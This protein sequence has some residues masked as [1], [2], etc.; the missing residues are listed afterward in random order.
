MRVDPSAIF[1]IL[2]LE[3]EFFTDYDESDLITLDYTFLGKNPQMLYTG[4]WAD[5][6]IKIKHHVGSE[7]EV[8]T[9]DFTIFVAIG[10][11][12]EKDLDGV[13]SICVLPA[14]G[15]FLDVSLLAVIEKN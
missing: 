5:I 11:A 15:D 1:S 13:L 8:T 6:T 7:S 2:F 9:V 4:V 3:P 14:Q 10:T 12:P